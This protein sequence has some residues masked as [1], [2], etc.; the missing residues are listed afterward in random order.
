VVLGVELVK[1]CSLCTGKILV[2]H[3]LP[4][5]FWRLVLM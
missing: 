4:Y 3:G 5:V 2:S 1:F